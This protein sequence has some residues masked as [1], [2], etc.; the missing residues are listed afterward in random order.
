MNTAQAQVSRQNVVASNNNLKPCDE[1]GFE[2]ELTH[3]TPAGELPTDVC[4]FC[5]SN[6]PSQYH[7]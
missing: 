1:C 3:V 7:N 4:R 6:F 2:D 5:R